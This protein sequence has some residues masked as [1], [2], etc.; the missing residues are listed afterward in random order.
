MI[1]VYFNKEYRGY[2][3]HNAALHDVMKAMFTE[4][5][6]QSVSLLVGVTSGGESSTLK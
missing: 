6:I 3:S 4:V 2:C 5:D 1:A